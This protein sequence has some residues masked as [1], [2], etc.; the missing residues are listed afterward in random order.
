[1]STFWDMSHLGGG[2]RGGRG[3]PKRNALRWARNDGPSFDARHPVPFRRVGPV[4][5]RPSRRYALPLSSRDFIRRWGVAHQFGGTLRG[6]RCT[7]SLVTWCHVP[8]Q[9]LEPEP[10]EPST[11]RGR[12]AFGKEK[13]HGNE[14]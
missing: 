14:A 1:M 3:V 10:R 12:A 2:G 13:G 5:R 6:G 8:A 7:R 11:S 4:Q 9:V